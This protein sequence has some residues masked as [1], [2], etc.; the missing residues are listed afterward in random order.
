MMLEGTTNAECLRKVDSALFVVCL[1]HASP[2]TLNDL[3]SNTL[4]GLSRLEKGV[5]VGT[6]TN[7]WY[8]KLQIIVTKNAKCG[9]NFEHTGVD[10]HTVLRFV[11]DVY[12]DTLLRFAKSINGKSPSIWSTHSPD[13]AERTPESFGHVS[14]T[15]RK[16]EWQQSNDLLLSMRFAETRLAD[17][18][19]QNEF[20]ALEFQGYGMRAIKEMGFSP[21][22]YVQMC[23]QAAYYSLYGRVECTY[24]PAMTKAFLHGRTES[25]RSVT[26]ESVA[27]VRRFCDDAPASVKMD[28]LRAACKK[29]TMNT[30]RCSKG[31]GQ[32]RHLYALF[33]IWRRSLTEDS[34][35]TSSDISAEDL[36]HNIP[37]I[38]ADPG[39]DKLATVILSTSN[40]G[41]PTLKMFGFGPVSQDGYGLGYIIKEN[42]ITICASSKHRQTQRFIDTLNS[43]LVE[44]RNLWKQSQAMQGRKLS[45]I[46]RARSYENLKGTHEPFGRSITPSTTNLPSPT[47]TESENAYLGGY[48]YFDIGEFESARSR[49]PSPEPRHRRALKKEIGRKLRLADY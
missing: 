20:A 8:D 19:H 42:G 4:C 15:P 27:F 17:L 47:L 11:S 35:D 3:A 14:T 39:W 29:H 9:I 1:D 12:M 37:S 40:C 16:L 25:I 28:S 34:S 2:Q 41:N 10:G 43:V 44:V 31:L 23:F 48:G 24:E 45:S 38:F 22:A 5:Q 21:D 30:V 7:R 33:C 26:K 49:Q 46:T 6:C 18:I 32:D 13:P 36:S